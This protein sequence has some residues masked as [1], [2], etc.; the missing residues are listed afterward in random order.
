MGRTRRICAVI[1]ALWITVLVSGRAAGAPILVGV[2]A[3]A[4]SDTTITF[5]SLANET[6]ITNQFSGLGVLYSGSL[7]AMTNPGDTAFFPG[8]GGGVIASD[9]RYSIPGG[10][11]PFSPIVATFSTNM[12]RVGFYVET[13][14]PDD[15]RVTTSRAGN[16]TGVLV[17]PSVLQASWF[18]VEDTAGIDKIT[19][20]VIGPDNHFIAIDDFKFAVP[21]PSSAGVMVG[22]SL[23]ACLRRRRRAI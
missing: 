18:G 20:E 4:P 2:G 5:N 11:A 8:N 7:F 14:A 22:L 12:A 16:T 23:L 3:F 17:F 19:I 9:W 6:P 1:A 10:G 21:E 15:T 13:N